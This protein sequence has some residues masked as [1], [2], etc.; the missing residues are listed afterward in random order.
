MTY[1][2]TPNVL[3]EKMK[4]E[5]I[6]IIDVRSNLQNPDA[7][8][9]LYHKSHLPGAYYLHLKNDL[10]GEV[11]THGGNH[12]LPSMKELAKKLGEMGIDHHTLVVI[13]DDENDMYASRA[14]WLL[15]YMGHEQTYILDGG[16]KAWKQCGYEVTQK[17]PSRKP[18]TFV[19]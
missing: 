6:V 4:K 17:T 14:W 11:Q 5:D 7:G 16:F 18:T 3:Q 9:A 19:P 1:L 12:P 10:S 15:Y 8:E 2:M 13:Y